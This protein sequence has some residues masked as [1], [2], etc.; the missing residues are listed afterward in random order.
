VRGHLNV[1]KRALVQVAA[2]N[3]GLLMRSN[4]SP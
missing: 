1:A 4:A 3:L 2:F